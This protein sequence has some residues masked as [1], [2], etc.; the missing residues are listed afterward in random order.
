MIRKTK[1]LT[2]LTAIMLAL[3][4]ILV[5][6]ATPEDTF[7]ADKSWNNMVWVTYGTHDGSGNPTRNFTVKNE[8][9]K[10]LSYSLVETFD[11]DDA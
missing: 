5:S 9:G 8:Y 6:A 11:N 2:K 7:D 1:T 10:E 3:S 4:G